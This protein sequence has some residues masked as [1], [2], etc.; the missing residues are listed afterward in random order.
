MLRSQLLS[1]THPLP[2][3]HRTNPF[4]PIFVWSAEERKSEDADTDLSGTREA[5]S[6]CQ[7]VS[8]VYLD[9]EALDLYHG[10]IRKLEGSQLIRVRWYGD[11]EPCAAPDDDDEEEE[12]QQ[13][14]QQR[15]KEEPIV[16]V[17][18]KEH[19]EDW[20]G[21][22]SEKRRFPLPAK[23]VVNFLEGN[24]DFSNG[25]KCDDQLKKEVQAA[26][27]DRKLYPR[28]RS[29]CNRIAFQL[30]HDD[31]VRLTL[32]LDLCFLRE[33][34]AEGSW[35]TDKSSILDADVC[36]FPYAVLEV[37]ESVQSSPLFEVYFR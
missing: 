7:A 16:F 12:E 9:N 15:E 35:Y 29:C 22:Q 13:Q 5:Q 6:I 36:E 26:V 23:D 10:R 27:R 32:D 30:P 18:R 14:Q 34:C 11:D 24:E 28:I 4:R 1:R 20:S 25:R 17:E 8:S 3:H 2:L 21:K 33:K 37:G 31:G 19:H